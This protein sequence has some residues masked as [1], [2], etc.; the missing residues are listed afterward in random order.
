VFVPKY[1]KAPQV[2]GFLFEVRQNH[3]LCTFMGGEIK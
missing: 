1:Q 3:L 2:R